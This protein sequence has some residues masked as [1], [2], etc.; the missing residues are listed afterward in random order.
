MVTK[1]GGEDA[2]SL[3]ITGWLLTSLHFLGRPDADATRAHLVCAYC[4]CAA[5]VSCLLHNLTGIFLRYCMLSLLVARLFTL[6]TFRNF[7]SSYGF[8]IVT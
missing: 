4:V 7:P 5:D 3:G 6:P 1:V 8:A 2:L